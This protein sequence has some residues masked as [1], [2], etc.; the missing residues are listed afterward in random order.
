[1]LSP[2]DVLII[3]AVALMIF[4]PDQL[5]KVAR[6]AGQLVR[7][8]QNTSQTFIREMERAADDMDLR[9]AVSFDTAPPAMNGPRP[10]AA[11]VAEAPAPTVAAR[12]RTHA[13]A[14]AE[15]FEP[16]PPPPAAPPAAVIPAAPPAAAE[17]MH[18]DAA[19]SGI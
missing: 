12:P 5:P 7:D 4:G 1:M 13:D 8:V 11:Q 3:G 2:P 15:N 9:E 6:K 16:G 14:A 19:G 10:S 17:H 18:D